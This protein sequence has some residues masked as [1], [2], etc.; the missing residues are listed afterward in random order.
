MHT[1]YTNIAAAAD[2]WIRYQL[3]VVGECHSTVACLVVV[4]C[5]AAVSFHSAPGN[6]FCSQRRYNRT[7]GPPYCIKCDSVISIE[8][9]L[10]VLGVWVMHS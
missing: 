5:R 4:Y 3:E 10:V 2:V 7:D 8:C 6:A 9:L 1:I